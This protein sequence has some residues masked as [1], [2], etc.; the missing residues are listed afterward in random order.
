[1]E[2]KHKN[3]IKKHKSELKSLQ[4]K[5]PVKIG[6]MLLAAHEKLSKRDREKRSNNPIRKKDN[7]C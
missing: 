4:E 2:S 3:E 6:K 7:K 5:A 1:M